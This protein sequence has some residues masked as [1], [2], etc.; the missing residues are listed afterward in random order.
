[1][2]VGQPCGPSWQN[3]PLRVEAG[4]GGG[5]EG[6]ERN[7]D[8]T[9]QRCISGVLNGVYYLDQLRAGVDQSPQRREVDRPISSIPVVTVVVCVVAVLAGAHAGGVGQPAV[10]S[11]STRGPVTTRALSSVSSSRRHGPGRAGRRSSGG[12][13]RRPGPALCP[14]PD[15]ARPEITPGSAGQTGSS[16]TPSRHCTTSR[17]TFEIE[18]QRWI[19]AELQG[20]M[21]VLRRRTDLDPNRVRRLEVVSGDDTGADSRLSSRG[22]SPSASWG[23]SLLADR[24]PLHPAVRTSPRRRARSAPAGRSC[25]R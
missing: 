5:V 19:K 17:S 21:L 10:C 15:R 7:A 14:P 18:D 12:R 13:P 16:T 22:R 1:M 23:R 9:G 8:R 2:A 24:S 3:R 20:G 6:L 11:I 4:G 25:A